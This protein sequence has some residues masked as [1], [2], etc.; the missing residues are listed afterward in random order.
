MTPRQRHPH[1]RP[2]RSPA[3]THHM[4]PVQ[5]PARHITGATRQSY[6]GS[7]PNT[8]VELAIRSPGP[9]A[10]VVCA[11]RT[12]WHARQRQ[13]RRR[14]GSRGA[15]DAHREPVPARPR[16]AVASTDA[17]P[18]ADGDGFDRG[19]IADAA[20]DRS[21]DEAV[22]RHSGDVHDLDRGRHVTRR[23][24]PRAARRHR[25]GVRRP[26]DRA[27]PARVPG[28]ERVAQRR[29]VRTGPTTSTSGSPYRSARRG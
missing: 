7:P 5:R 1:R 29:G 6:C 2:R 20:H 27:D 13:W 11:S 9:A 16:R 14:G 4:A 22:A 23:G 25:A 8:D 15:A 10:A 28:T 3:A 18:G 21:A 26:R 12:C 17:G 24:R 19:P